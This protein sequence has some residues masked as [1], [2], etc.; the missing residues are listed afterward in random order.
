MT[1]FNLSPSSCLTLSFSFLL[2]FI[3]LPPS[4]CH[5]L[6]SLLPTSPALRQNRVP[7]AQ[8]IFFHYQ[9]STWNTSSLPSLPPLSLPQMVVSPSR[10]ETRL[11]GITTFSRSISDFPPIAPTKHPGPVLLLRGRFLFFRRRND[12]FCLKHGDYVATREDQRV[13]TVHHG[14]LS[15]TTVP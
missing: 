15:W 12:A 3:S 14:P 4:V 5:P 7:R 1:H 11:S 13:L 10:L 8:S 6:S 9:S 2:L